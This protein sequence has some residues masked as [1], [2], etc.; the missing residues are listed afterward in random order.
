MSQQAVEYAGYH[1]VRSLIEI[2]REV[3]DDD[4]VGVNA[5]VGRNTLT[6][7]N[8]KKQIEGIVSAKNDFVV[9]LLFNH[10]VDYIERGRAPKVGKQPPIDDLKDWAQRN[11]IPTDADTLWRIS[12]AI[13]RDGYAGRPVFATLDTRIAKGFTDNWADRLFEALTEDLEAFFNT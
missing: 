13:W 1:I 2:A 7:S 10:Y 9:T 11:G 6:D 5:K 12:Y 4:S 8:L 3:L